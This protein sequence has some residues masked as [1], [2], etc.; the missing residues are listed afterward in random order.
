MGPENAASP[1]YL[2]KVSNF[3]RLTFVTDIGNKFSGESFSINFEIILDGQLF[4]R[5]M[6][7][8]HTK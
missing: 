1:F 2:K 3:L 8:L 7:L 5:R 6:C 4:S